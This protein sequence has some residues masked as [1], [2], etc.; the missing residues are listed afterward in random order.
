[1]LRAEVRRVHAENFGFYG[2]RKVWRQLGREGTRVARCTVARLMRQLGLRGVVRGKET[3]T[4]MP[5]KGA[6]CPADRVNRQFH[7]L[8]QA[9]QHAT[10][11]PARVMPNLGESYRRTLAKLR[12]R[13][14]G[15]TQDPEAMAIARQL[16]A[17][18]VVHPSQ[19]R[20]PPGFTVEGHLAKMLT[21]AQPDVPGRVAE[22]IACAAKLSVKEGP[23]GCSPWRSRS[24]YWGGPCPGSRLRRPIPAPRR[25]S[26][27]GRRPAPG[28]CRRI[29]GC[30]AAG[31]RLP[32]AGHD[33]QPGRHPRVHVPDLER[34]GHQPL[35]RFERPSRWLTATETLPQQPLCGR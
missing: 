13:L 14:S 3:R 18:V 35:E 7:R 32:G 25:P 10:P 1:M 8:T 29:Q 11:T 4:T 20:K 19:P 21:T 34:G 26:I 23:R 16:I 9:I 31:E 17:S 5:D 24:G 12:E 22:S 27:S 30:D 28:A 15:P 2:V 33:A 6:P